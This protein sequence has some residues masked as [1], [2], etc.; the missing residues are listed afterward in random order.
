MILFE[1]DTVTLSFDR[2]VP[3]LIGTFTGETTSENYRA[4]LDNIQK[5]MMINAGNY[6][7]IGYIA[8]TRIWGAINPEDFEYTGE[9]IPEWLEGGLTHEAMIVSKEEYEDL[10]DKEAI[11]LINGLEV[12]KFDTIEAARE[13]FKEVF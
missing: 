5:F 11:Y 2:D 8:D 4:L 3:C 9:F 1:K 12:K 7:N 10:E 13:W 6:E